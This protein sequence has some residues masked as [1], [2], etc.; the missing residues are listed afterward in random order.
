MGEKLLV[1]KRVLPLLG[2]ANELTKIFVS[3]RK[4]IQVSKGKL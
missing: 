1:A 3:A 4:T 2:E